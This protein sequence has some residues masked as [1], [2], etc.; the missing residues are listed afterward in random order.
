MPEIVATLE[1]T[2]LDIATPD[3]SAPRAESKAFG[4]VAC[5]AV[6]LK[7][8]GPST[9]CSDPM[10]RFPTVVLLFSKVAPL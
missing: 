6:T 8:I 9:L 5:G 10:K 2:G 4:P 3:P 1:K 7:Y